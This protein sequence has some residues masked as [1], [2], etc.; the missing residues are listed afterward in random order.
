M[1]QGGQ[2]VFQI[3]SHHPAGYAQVLSLDSGHLSSIPFL[4]PIGPRES[5]ALLTSFQ[6]PPLTL[7]PGVPLLKTGC[8]VDTVALVLPPFLAT[9]GCVRLERAQAWVSHF[10]S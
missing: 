9:L 4:S 1:E 2:R 3:R 8:N 5:Q 7:V 6:V 10:I